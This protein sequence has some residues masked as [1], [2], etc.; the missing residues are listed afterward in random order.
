M[1]YI[2][3]LFSILTALMAIAAGIF[4]LSSKASANDY[5]LGDVT[6]SNSSFVAQVG[7]VQYESLQEAVNNADG[8]YVKL[9]ADADEAVKAEEDLHLDLNG[10]QLSNLSV[11]G[12]LY[13]RRHRCC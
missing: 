9:L 4:L 11:D 6:S 1:K 8:D 2:Q 3:R 7:S 5:K 10:K 12:T 13:H